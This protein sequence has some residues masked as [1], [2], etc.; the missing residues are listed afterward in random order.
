MSDFSAEVINAARARIGT[1]FREHFTPDLCEK[2]TVTVDACMDSGFD[3]RGYDCSGLII[4]SICDVVG[5]ALQDWP[6]EFRHNRQMVR[7]MGALPEAEDLTFL[8]GEED[9]SDGRLDTSPRS[10]HGGIRVAHD[11]YIHANGFTGVVEESPFNPG[12][13]QYHALSYKTL[14][15]AVDIRM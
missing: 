6:R 1:P 15:H 13:K 4:A 2:G 12:G 14:L 11:R 7:L 9:L 8:I 10:I 5:V 3:R